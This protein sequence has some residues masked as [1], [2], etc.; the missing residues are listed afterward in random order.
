MKGRN[1]PSFPSR[2]YSRLTISPAILYLVTTRSSAIVCS[3]LS[4]MLPL[5]R[6]TQRGQSPTCKA[7]RRPLD[8]RETHGPRAS[9][10]ARVR[11][12]E[13]AAARTAGHAASLSLAGCC[14]LL[15]NARWPHARGNNLRGCQL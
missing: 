11:R 5:Y 4:P 7:E 2:P 9:R 14:T 13:K 10:R 6:K 3:S 12:Q 1:P 15:C 8:W